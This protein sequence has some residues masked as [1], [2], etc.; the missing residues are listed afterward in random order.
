[1]EA[2][3]P[4]ILFTLPIGAYLAGSVPFGW[5]MGR[6]RGVDIRKQGSGNI[7]AT[8]VWRVLG[9]R[10][11]IACF[12]LDVLKGL[13][14]VYLAGIYLGRHLATEQGTLSAKGQGIWLLV[15]AGAIIGH[16]F[17]VFLGFRG[18]KGVAT[19]LGVVVGIWPYFTLTALPAF[20]V[21][22]VIFIWSRYVSLASIVAAAVFPILFGLFIRLTPGWQIENLWPLMVFC[23]VIGA[24][25]ILRHCSN[26]VRLLNGTE[27]KSGRNDGDPEVPVTPKGSA[28]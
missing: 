8:N 17:S 23:C 13:A 21:W 19:S 5:L 3:S 9:R 26:I 6:L 10:W 24:L 7:G 15:G 28:S 16:M 12:M 20:C 2:G 18:G 25:V 4:L 11:G 1:M 22:A 27:A 14:P